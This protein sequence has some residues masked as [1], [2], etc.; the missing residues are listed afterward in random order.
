[1]PAEDGWRI[2]RSE[3]RIAREP[4]GPPRNRGAF[5]RAREAVAAYAFTDPTI[6]E[7]HFDPR[8]PLRGRRMLLELK[9]LGLHYL[10][11]VEVTEVRDESDAARSVFGFRYDTLA[12][13]IERGAE[14]FLVEQDHATGDCPVRHRGAL[15]ARRAVH[16]VDARRFQRARAGVPRAVASVAR[17]STC[18]GCSPSRAPPAVPRARSRPRRRSAR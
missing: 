6:V 4:P 15:A 16:A 11:G 2:E 14:W 10:C 17:R 5:A 9:V 7:A 12:G 13:H 8:A 1:M 18:A 3:A